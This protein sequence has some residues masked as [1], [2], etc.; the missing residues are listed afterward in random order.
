[1]ERLYKESIYPTFL[2][3]KVEFYPAELAS[4]KAYSSK[5]IP[6]SKQLIRLLF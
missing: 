3:Y 6:V 5:K 1:M 2:W 4:E